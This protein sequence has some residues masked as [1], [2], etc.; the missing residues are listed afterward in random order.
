[1]TRYSRR[2]TTAGSQND[3]AMLGDRDDRVDF[4]GGVDHL[5][6][7]RPDAGSVRRKDSVVVRVRLD[8]QDDLIEFRDVLLKVELPG[9]FPS[10]GAA[11]RGSRSF[12]LGP[13]RRPPA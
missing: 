7:R 8:A 9:L 1:M 11:L 5:D 6:D 4:D 13:V 10:L 3:S 2:L 12:P